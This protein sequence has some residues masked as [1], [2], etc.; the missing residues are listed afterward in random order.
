MLLVRHFLKKALYKCTALTFNFISVPYVP[1]F[2]ELSEESFDIPLYMSSSKEPTPLNLSICT[3]TINSITTKNNRLQMVLPSKKCNLYCIGESSWCL[4]NR[5]K[6][7]KSHVMSAIYKHSISNNNPWA[8]ISH[9]NI[10]DQDSKQLPEKLG[11]PFILETTTLPSCVTQ[12]KCTS[13]KSSSTF[14]GHIYL[15]VRCT[16]W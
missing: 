13:Q 14:L 4:E 8:N 2:S 6:E 10:I 16:K 7:R 11:K 9:F 12:E 1:Q 5:V 3:L 15:P